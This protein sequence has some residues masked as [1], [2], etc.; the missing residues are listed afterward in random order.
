VKLTIHEFGPFCRPD[1][2]QIPIASIWPGT[3][4]E[5]L[6]RTPEI[7]SH[8]T[9]NDIRNVLNFDLGGVR[10]AE[11]ASSGRT[12]SPKRSETILPSP[13]TTTALLIRASL[14]PEPTGLSPARLSLLKR[15]VS[16]PA[17]V[18]RAIPVF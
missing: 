14:A 3:A 11:S 2:D 13:V 17:E 15:C 10:A 1:A 9:T 6:I 8:L 12:I 7:G 5:S 18:S 4:C 16:Q